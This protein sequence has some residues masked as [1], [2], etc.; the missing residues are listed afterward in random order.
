MEEVVMEGKKVIDAHAHVFG[1]LDF[2]PPAWHEQIF[3]GKFQRKA[4]RETLFRKPTMR[5]PGSLLKLKKTPEGTLVPQ[6]ITI[7]TTA[8]E[9]GPVT[10]QTI[11]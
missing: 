5:F 8:V 11:S 10:T 7:W 2:F 9:A 4:L 6:D 3:A 1:S